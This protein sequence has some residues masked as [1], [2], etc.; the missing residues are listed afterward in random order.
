LNEKANIDFEVLKES[1]NRIPMYELVGMRVEEVRAGYSRFRMPFRHEITQPMGIIH[2]GA[3]ATVADSA[4]AV[5]LWGLVGMDKIFTTIEMKINYIAPVASGE[6]IAEGT[7]VHCGRRTA[8]GEVTLTDQSG[9]L[10]GKCIATYMIIP[11][12]ET[13]AAAPTWRGGGE[14]SP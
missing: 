6:V 9:K 5:A 1:V 14:S 13:N 7:I 4:V 8:V 11:M 2:G 10:V 12:D 3:L